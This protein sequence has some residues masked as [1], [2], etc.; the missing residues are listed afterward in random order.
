MFNVSFSEV[1]KSYSRVH[2]L[3]KFVQRKQR[4]AI[5]WRALLTSS[6]LIVAVIALVCHEY[7]LV[8]M[9]SLLPTYL[10]DVLGVPKA[11]NGF[12]SALPLL[13]LWLSKTIS[14]SFSSYLSARKQGCCLLGRTPLVKVFNAIGSAG[15]GL[16]LAVVPFLTRQDQIAYAIVAM[17]SANAFAG[18]HTPGVQTALLQIAPAY[19]GVITGIAFSVVAITS[20]INKVTNGLILDMATHSQWTM[21]FEISAVVALLPVVF[22]TL[23]G[24]ADLQPWA[25]PNIREQPKKPDTISQRV[26]FTVYPENLHST[27]A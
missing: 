19:T 9:I 23:W 14:S 6:P 16:S 5:P 10:N 11:T 3:K 25:V 24:S 22:F 7:P 13:T 15:L 26:K 27:S 1:T 17:C 4:C 8:I 18:F 20:I 21:L 2:I 12:L